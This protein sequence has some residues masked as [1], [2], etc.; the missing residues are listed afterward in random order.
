MTRQP[1]ALDLQHVRR[2]DEAADWLMRLENPARTEADYTDWLCWCDADPENLSAFETVQRASQGFEALKAEGWVGEMSRGSKRRPGITRVVWA[3]AATVGAVA[4]AL[5]V[6]HYT[7]K[8]DTVA[9]QFAANPINR[10]ATLPDG[11]RMILG[12][13]SR[14]DVD[15]NGPQRSLDL[16][17][18]EAYFKVK[19]DKAHPFVVRAGEVN[20]TAVGTAFDVKRGKDKVTVTVEEG[21]VDVSSRG[22]DGNL[23]NWRAE[24]G[25]QVTYSTQH[26]TASIA[27]VDPSAELAWRNGELA[28]RYEALGTV[29][30]DLNRYSNRRIVITDPRVAKIQ[31][32]GTAFASSV[33]NWLTGIEQAYPVT[34]NRTANGD[35]VL[36]LRE[37]G[38]P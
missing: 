24:A 15:F 5:A 32:T 30:E 27:S 18:G 7:R 38:S 8:P 13:Q 6:F 14:V 20:V 28:Y 22:T 37:S 16:S 34:V 1:A 21:T 26:R 35:I 11:S 17:A 12:T 4:V 2:L 19:H 23:T 33:D 25:Y 9:Q 10:A 36:S 3:T 29:V 31:F